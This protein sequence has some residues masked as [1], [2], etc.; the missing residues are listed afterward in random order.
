[1]HSISTNTVMGVS[2]CGKTSVGTALAESL[3]WEFIEGDAYH[4]PENIEK[5]S[6]GSPLTD[7]DRLPWLNNLHDL[8]QKKQSDKISVVLACSAL[9]RRYRK[10]LY[11]GL[12]GCTFVYL[13]GDYAFILERMRQ[14]EHFMKP[15]LLQSQFEFLQE[16]EGA[17][18]V[19]INIPVVQIVKK[20]TRFYN[21]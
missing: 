21:F 19:P 1:V 20:I 7:A 5:M 15:S 9:K 12:T 14:R 16:P 4:P 17:L 18:V 6:G 13:K 2:G 3:G 8:L 10:I 11:D